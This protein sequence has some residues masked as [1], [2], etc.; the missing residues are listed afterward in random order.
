MK[1]LILLCLAI[2]LITGIQATGKRTDCF[3][4]VGNETIFCD[5]IF[6]GKSTFRLVDDGKQLMRIQSPEIKAFSMYGN[7]F[8]RLPVVNTNNDTSGWAF[9]QFIASN[10]GYRLYRYCSN[11]VHFDP[12]TGK[13]A[14]EN[15]VYRYYIF[16]GGKYVKVLD[17]NNVKSELAKYGVRLV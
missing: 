8:E 15:A 3:V 9:M 10:N 12:V 14:P 7:L 17:E 5:K 11:C 1:T 13:I 2:L 4:V 6:V 16:K